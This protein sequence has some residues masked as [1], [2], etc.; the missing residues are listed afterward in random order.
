MS[1]GI[2]LR[3]LEVMVGRQLNFMNQGMINMGFQQ[4]IM[5]DFRL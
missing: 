4:I 3:S 2:Q 1:D 5:G